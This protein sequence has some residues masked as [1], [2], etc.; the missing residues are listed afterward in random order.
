M[1]LILFR[2][3]I[4]LKVIGDECKFVTAEMT[5][6]WN[7]ATLPTIPLNYK[8]ED[9]FNANEFGLLYYCLPDKTSKVKS[10]LEERKTK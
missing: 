7:E 2:H 3:N 8:L 1:N 6:S 9:I 5:S 4:S 10:S